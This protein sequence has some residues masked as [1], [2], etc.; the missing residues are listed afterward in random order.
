[1]TV[2]EFWLFFDFFQKKFK[3]TES[4]YFVQIRI[5]NYQIS[6]KTIFTLPESSLGEKN[7]KSDLGIF[8]IWAGFFFKKSFF[9]PIFFY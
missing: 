6:R 5:K 3:M 9:G 7:Q 4:S 1:M 2:L 8:F